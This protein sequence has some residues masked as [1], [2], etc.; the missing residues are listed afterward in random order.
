MSRMFRTVLILVLVTPLLAA[1]FG[2]DEPDIESVESYVKVRSRIATDGD[3]QGDY[4]EIR[5]V[6]II[7]KNKNGSDAALQITYKVRAE[8]HLT[9]DLYRAGVELYGKRILRQVANAGAVLRFTFLIDA[10]KQGDDW[11]LVKDHSINQQGSM[12]EG[13][14]LSY[15]SATPYVLDGTDEANALREQKVAEDAAQR[16]KTEAERQARAEAER[17]RKIV[18]EKARVARVAALRKAITGVWLAREPFTQNGTFYAVNHGHRFEIPEGTETQGVIKLEGF[19]R[20]NP[21]IATTI[22][23]VYKIDPSGTFW[24]LTEK[25]AFR[26][27]RDKRYPYAHSWETTVWKSV[28]DGNIQNLSYGKYAA[29][30][31][32]LDSVETAKRQKALRKALTGMWAS[33]AP[34]TQNEQ[35]YSYKGRSMGVR[36]TFEGGNGLEG[37]AR[38]R[39]FV[40][41]DR[42]TYIDADLRYMM[43][44]TAEAVWLYE[45]EGLRFKALDWR[46]GDLPWRMEF[47]EGIGRLVTKGKSEWAFPVKKL[48]A[49]LVQA[50]RDTAS[51]KEWL[52]QRK[53]ELLM[54]YQATEV[55]EDRELGRLGVTTAGNSHANVLVTASV[56]LGNGNLLRVYGKGP[57][58]AR[59]WIG[60]TVLV[61]GL[62]KPGESGIVQ[63]KK[64]NEFQSMGDRSYVHGGQIYYTQ[65]DRSAGYS[66]KLLERF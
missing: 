51:Q 61:E 58:G 15:Y 65:K 39:Y 47:E 5:N 34:M 4:F 52:A 54:Q 14:P 17:Q 32:K 37:T 42:E 35:P 20:N 29:K 28:P 41:D 50:I 43:D 57:Y 40:A 6:E 60:Q 10:E 16:A 13:Q 19:A 24:M 23:A 46:F 56:E 12:S 49:R 9:E 30:F 22:D 63:V 26:I 66:I 31:E 48:S 21:A 62:L 25:D 18:E 1:C 8:V 36:I 3:F 59:S 38:A 11:V 64:L 45:P 55:E 53:T 2:P 44:E 27:G 33:T 7:A